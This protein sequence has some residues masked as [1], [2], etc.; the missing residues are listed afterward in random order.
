MCVQA[1]LRRL[2][3]AASRSV[4]RLLLFLC[5]AGEALLVLYGLI[6]VATGSIRAARGTTEKLDLVRG[7][8]RSNL[9]AWR[10]AV[11]VDGLVGAENSRPFARVGAIC[12]EVGYPR[13]APLRHFQRGD[14]AATRPPGMP[15]GCK[16]LGQ[17]VL[18]T[19]HEA[20]VLR[21]S[22]ACSRC[23]RRG[24]KWIARCSEIELMHPTRKVGPDEI[25]RQRAWLRHSCR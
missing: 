20:G 6:D 4:R 3:F 17:A 21:V 11:P 1:C 19:A 10:V 13:D 5:W 14:C 15:A 25:N 24:V 12:S 16:R 7:V 22:S 9:V 8:M 18:P 23:G 2:H